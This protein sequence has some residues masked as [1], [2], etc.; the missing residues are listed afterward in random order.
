[1]CRNPS[2]SFPASGGRDEIVD[3]LAARG[4]TGTGGRR[5]GAVARRSGAAQR[6]RTLHTRA[7]RHC[8][9]SATRHR[10]L[11]EVST[12]I[13]KI[14]IKVQSQNLNYF[15]N[16]TVGKCCTFLAYLIF[17]TQCELYSKYCCPYYFHNNF[18][19]IIFYTAP[20]VGVISA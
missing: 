7:H 5:S 15:H 6:P 12:L 1:M 9:H 18:S 17:G 11:R 3:R 10:S 20:D 16:R 19:T 2:P 13:E 8:E 14:T 4:A